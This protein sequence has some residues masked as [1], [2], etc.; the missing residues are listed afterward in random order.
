MMVAAYMG[1]KPKAKI[2]KDKPVFLT[3]PEFED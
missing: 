3:L 2:S 1:H